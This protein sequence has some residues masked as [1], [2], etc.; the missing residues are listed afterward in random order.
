MT[1][2]IRYLL[3]TFIN[4]LVI[5]LMTNWVYWSNEVLLPSPFY[6]V[7]LSLY[8][9]TSFLKYVIGRTETEIQNSWKYNLGFWIPSRRIP[10]VEWHLTVLQVLLLF[11][12][13]FPSVMLPI[14]IFFCLTDFSSMKIKIFEAN[15]VCQLNLLLLQ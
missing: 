5:N 7:Q 4:K 6:W 15:H 9:K 11:N 10:S 3:M 1:V 13:D 8:E 14:R 2:C 12:L